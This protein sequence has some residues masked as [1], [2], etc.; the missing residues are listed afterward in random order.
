MKK[1]PGFLHVAVQPATAATVLIDDK[2]AGPAPLES[3]PVDAG[4]H[5]IRVQTE[6]FFPVTQSVQIRGMGE[7]QALAIK[8]HPA[9]GFLSVKSD[10]AQAT[11]K[12]DGVYAGQTP[13]VLEP[14]QGEHQIT[15]EKDG[16]KPANATVTVKAGVSGELTPF[17]LE[18]VDGY[19]DVRSQPMGATVAIGDQFHGRTPVSFPLVSGQTYRLKLTKPGFSQ[20]VRDVAIEGKTTAAVNAILRPEY[21]IIFIRSRPSGA[22]LRVDGKDLHKTRK[23]TC[24]AIYRHRKTRP[25]HRRR[26][27]SRSR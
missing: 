16:W 5:E 7:T 24:P 10:P 8:L 4:K 13:V 23:R 14:I 20:F 12:L 19:L 9:W 17:K 6:R 22:I 15:V 27:A 25:L 18:K 1:L 21:G 26:V 3:Y 2:M 11:V